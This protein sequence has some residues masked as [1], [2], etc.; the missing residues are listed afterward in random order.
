MDSTSFPSP[1]IYIDSIKITSNDK[2]SGGFYD[3]L[4]K[5]QYE[6]LQKWKTELQ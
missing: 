2:N 6:A 4:N 5:D 3:S 1:I